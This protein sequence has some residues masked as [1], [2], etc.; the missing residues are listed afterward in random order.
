M[1]M[2]IEK[3]SFAKVQDHSILMSQ[4]DGSFKAQAEDV[5]SKFEIDSVSPRKF[6]KHYP[7]DNISSEA[8]LNTNLVTMAEA[9][10]ANFIGHVQIALG[11]KVIGEEKVGKIYIQP[12]HKFSYIQTKVEKLQPYAFSYYNVKEDHIEIMSEM[13]FGIEIY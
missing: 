7:I 5:L 13:N 8:D 9:H 1:P 11:D 10:W 4:L 2:V 6:G 12:P 3:E